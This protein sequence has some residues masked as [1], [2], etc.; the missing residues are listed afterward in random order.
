MLPGPG[1]PLRSPRFEKGVASGAPG[2]PGGRFIGRGR[3]AKLLIDGSNG[4]PRRKPDAE[5][6]VLRLGKVAGPFQ[7]LD[8]SGE[9]SRARQS[10]DRHLQ[11]RVG[12]GEAR[13]DR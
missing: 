5:A 10:R 7:S 12:L 3:V 9:G 11:G 2:Q 6:V 13:W 8:S 4:N 1:L